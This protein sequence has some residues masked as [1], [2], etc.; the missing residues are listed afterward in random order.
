MI[1]EREVLDVREPPGKAMGKVAELWKPVEGTNKIMCTACARYCKIGEGQVGLCGIRGVHEGKLWLYV[2]G[3]VIT[4]HVDPIEKKPV[5][6]Y[7]P[8]SKIFSIATTGCNW[9]CHPA[10]TKILLADGNQKSVE[11]VQPGDRLWSYNVDGGYQIVP[12]VVT[13]TGQRLD[14]I[15]RARIGSR[16]LSVLDATS[17]HPV[18]T[19]GGWTLLRDL[20]PGDR[21]LK[22]WYQN[23]AS[24]K[25]NRAE[26]IAHADF[27]CGV[28]G[29]TVLGLSAWNQHRGACY[30]KDAVFSEGDRL[31]RSDRMRRR[32][33]MYD[34]SVARKA[35][36]TSRAR[37]EIDPTHGWHANAARLATWRHRHP[38]EGQRKLYEILDVMAIAYE[39]EYRIDPEIRLPNSKKHYV[40]DAA[41]IEQRIDI[42]VDGFWHAKSEEVRR[43]DRIRDAT[44]EENGWRVVRIWGRDVFHHPEAVK[45]LIEESVAPVLKT[46]KKM[47]LPV[48]SI[49]RTDRFEPVYSFECISTHN[50]VA[51]GVVVH[52]CRY[53][54]LPGTKV[55]TD[56]GQ[57]SIEAVF[58][59]ARKT[60]N[61][62]I[63]SVEGRTALTHKG[64]WKRV[65]SAFEHLYSGRTL[66]I[67]VDGLPTLRCTPDHRVF[68][69]KHG[70]MLEQVR[71]D[72]LR[73]GQLLAVP[74][75]AALGTE[76]LAEASQFVSGHNP[77]NQ[78]ILEKT[79]KVARETD[80]HLLVRVAEILEEVYVGPVY[81]IEVEEDHS[82]T[83][84]FMAVANCQNADISQRRKVEGIE[85]EPQ[86]VV[87]MTLEQGC[88]GLAYTYN[89]PTIFI[90]FARD[91]GMRARQ[92]GLM[93]IFVSNGYD[94]PET[95]AEMPKF[96]DCVTVDFKGSGETNFVR[97]YINIPNADPIFQTLL[98]TRDTKKIHIEITDLIVPQVGDDLGAARHLSKWVH[99]NLG[100]DTP[101]HFLRFHPDYKMMEF[102][103]TPVETLE[104]HCAVAKEEGLKYVYIGNVP[105]HPLENTYCPGCGAIAIKRYGFDTTGWYLGKDN[106][107]KKCGYKLAIFGK[108]EQTAKE[109]RFYSVLYHR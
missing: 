109:N 26:S 34:P 78:V 18:L 4:G 66:E 3:R 102:P 2:Y 105:G 24:W 9:L 53:C 50:Y 20:V 61:P 19:S 72:A 64:R 75:A 95:V 104:K 71:A 77:G 57:V 76:F 70:S 48:H 88:Q 106:Q 46:N 81:N 14:W 91:I 10:G 80:G 41:I 23:T 27:A 73:V 85:V 90:E 56:E 54:F 37:F 99:D 35:L 82:Y 47:W 92:A 43:S 12:S 55:L 15:Y 108:L 22:V 101:I 30:T 103:W 60:G 38:S 65:V 21:V 17:E 68:V 89:Q 69:S 84:N 45:D 6:H 16:G 31:A 83:A 59:T 33:P 39:R 98:D 28:C 5:S 8:G 42:E 74:R 97:K 86:D 96:L 107:C 79:L 25:R 32:N 29:E 13:H 58:A 11:D 36:E 7:R 93:N 100:P 1:S 44:L 67:R 49:T 40:A 87:R 94:T 51:D 63:R 62:E 52:N